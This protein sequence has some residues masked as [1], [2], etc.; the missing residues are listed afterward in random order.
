MLS[1]PFCAR[2]ISAWARTAA[3]E[4]ALAAYHAVPH[5]VA[6]SSGTAGL[7]LALLTLGIGEGDE[8]IVPS[9]AF[10]RRGQRRPPGSRHAGLCGD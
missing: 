8:V 1:P 10:H 6:V 4:A 3:F 9:F 5:A 7:H 2:R